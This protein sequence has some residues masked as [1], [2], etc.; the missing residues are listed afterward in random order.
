[1]IGLIKL[2]GCKIVNV[3]PIIVPFV[4]FCLLHLGRQTLV[5][6][7]SWIAAEHYFW[8]TFDY[9]LTLTKNSEIAIKWVP[10]AKLL[11]NRNYIYTLAVSD[12]NTWLWRADENVAVLAGIYIHTGVWIE[13]ENIALLTIRYLELLHHQLFGFFYLSLEPSVFK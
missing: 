10:D 9:G 13:Q 3:K 6:E 5:C 2:W 12:K 1:M 8:T 4:K 11:G 7:L